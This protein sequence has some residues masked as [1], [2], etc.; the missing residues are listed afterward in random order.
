MCIHEEVIL[1]ERI[2]QKLEQETSELAQL[3][4]YLQSRRKK[5]TKLSNIRIWERCIDQ[6]IDVLDK[7][8][9]IEV[10]KTK[11]PQGYQLYVK[12]ALKTEHDTTDEN[13]CY[14]DEDKAKYG[15]LIAVLMFIYMM[16]RPGSPSY[17][18]SENSLKNFLKEMGITENSCFGNQT[19]LN[20]LLGAAYTAEFISQGWLAFTKGTD[21]SGRDT[22]TYE[23]GPRAKSVVDPMTI[24]RT[25][26]AMDGSAPH[27]WR[28]HYQ[29][30][31]N[32]T[33]RNG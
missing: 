10:C 9:G 12:N 25:Y 27:H 1:D 13:H 19:N 31:Q 8:I 22:V 2:N 16:H 18:V 30:A 32:A 26:C 23:W 7:I 3:I 5:C 11:T 20:K 6:A 14:S 28:L 4:L 29:E 24:L 21:E 33:A 17:T 15:L